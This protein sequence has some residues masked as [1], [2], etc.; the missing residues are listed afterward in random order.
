MTE[1]AAVRR[2]QRVLEIGTGSGYQAAVL[3]ALG[4]EVYTIE[5]VEQLGKRA[6]TDLARLGYGGV[7]TRIGDGYQGWPAGGAVRRD[8]RDRGS[9]RRSPSRSSSSSSR[10]AAGHPGG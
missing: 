10:G 8:H 9:R 1:L 6:A 5:I 4:A 7:K 2:V 3:A